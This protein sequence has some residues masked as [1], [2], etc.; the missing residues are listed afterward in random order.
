MTV[1]EMAGTNVLVVGGGGGET[2]V[3]AGLRDNEGGDVGSCAGK[4]QF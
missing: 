4:V 3:L 2:C 1:N